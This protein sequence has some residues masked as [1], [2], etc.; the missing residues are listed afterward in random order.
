MHPPFLINTSLQRGESTPR[1]VIPSPRF[2][3]AGRGSGRGVHITLPTALLDLPLFNPLQNLRRDL[4]ERIRSRITNQNHRIVQRADQRGHCGMRFCAKAPKSTRRLYPNVIVGVPQAVG[5]SSHQKAWVFCQHRQGIC[6]V[7]MGIGIT[8]FLGLTILDQE[9]RHRTADV[10]TGSVQLQNAITGRGTTKMPGFKH[11]KKR[12]KA[13]LSDTS[14]R[15]HRL[16]PA[17]FSARLIY[18]PGELRDRWSPVRPKDPESPYCI[19]CQSVAVPQPLTDE[20]RKFPQKESE[21]SPRCRWL[22]FDPSHQPRQSVGSQM[23]DSIRSRFSLSDESSFLCFITVPQFV[24]SKPLTELL[25]SIH[26]FPVPRPHSRNDD[27]NHH[28]RD[29]CHQNPP[30]PFHAPTISQPLKTEQ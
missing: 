25:P 13:L 12:R 30:S 8:V 18:Y 22:I 1:E 26:R 11:L 2:C 5:Q 23:A 4:S 14:Q 28:A 20:K 24:R 3:V 19:N 6:Q 10:N 29:H 27:P 7:Q 16:P 15:M 21:A 17:I 9:R